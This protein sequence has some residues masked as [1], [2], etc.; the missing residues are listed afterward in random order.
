M[1]HGGVA[2]R[3]VGARSS[4]D[5]VEPP[6]RVSIVG[7]TTVGTEEAECAVILAVTLVGWF[8]I[9]HIRQ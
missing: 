2:H 8:E 3:G 6:L 5:V 9:G 4:T 7:V 1:R